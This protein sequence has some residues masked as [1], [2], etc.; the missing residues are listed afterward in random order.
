MLKKIMQQCKGN[1]DLLNDAT[2]KKEETIGRRRCNSMGG[3]DA[4]EKEQDPR[5]VR[6]E[7]PNA[8]PE[9]P[10]A[11]DGMTEHMDNVYAESKPYDPLANIGKVFA[12][13]TTQVFPEEFGKIVRKGVDYMTVDSPDPFYKRKDKNKKRGRKNQYYT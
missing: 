10:E 1:Q 13:I 8:K 3:I 12:D 9:W 11:D 2:G 6:S 5:E 7:Q 4:F